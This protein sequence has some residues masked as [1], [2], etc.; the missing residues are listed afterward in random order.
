L[1]DFAESRGR[2][3]IENFRIT[4]EVRLGF[5][6]AKAKYADN[7]AAIRLLQQLQGQRAKE[8]SPDEKTILVRYVGWGG[9]PQAFDFNNE[10]W[11]AEYGEL[12]SLLS[13]EDYAKA[14]R[15]T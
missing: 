14:R 15:S 8:A 3:R 1:G 9:L 5:G 13:P 11:S 4:P 7:I 12:K 2:Y 10:K 6:G